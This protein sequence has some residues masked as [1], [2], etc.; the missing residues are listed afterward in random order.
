MVSGHL[1]GHLPP[2]LSALMS[3]HTC[4]ILETRLRD[5]LHPRAI[6]V[7]FSASISTQYRVAHLPPFWYATARKTP[8]ASSTLRL[9]LACRSEHLPILAILAMPGCA[10]FPTKCR[11]RQCR[12]MPPVCVISDAGSGVVA[13]PMADSTRR[14]SPSMLATGVGFSVI[15]TP[16]C[17]AWACSKFPNLLHSPCV[18]SNVSIAAPPANASPRPH[19]R[20]FVVIYCNSPRPRP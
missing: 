3:A 10:G 14:D 20:G 17:G 18:V 4:P 1:S 9:R 2:C 8:Q 19:G 6:K 12:S 16:S 5:G 15:V 7:C 13:L 11:R